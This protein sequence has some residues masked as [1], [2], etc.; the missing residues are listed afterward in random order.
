V[1]RDASGLSGSGTVRRDDG[2]AGTF[3]FGDA[4]RGLQVP[5]GS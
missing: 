3:M 1:T 2:K 5:P 4:A